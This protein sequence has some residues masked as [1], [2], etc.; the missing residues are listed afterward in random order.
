VTL[1]THIIAGLV[2]GKITGNYPLALSTSVLIDADHL[3][4]YFKSG[5]LTKPKKLWAAVTDHHDPYGDQRGYL[6]NLAVF[7]IISAIAM[8][9][10][11]VAA[12]PFVV[13]W[14]VHIILDALDK[15]PYWPLYPYKKFHISGFIRYASFQEGLFAL[16]LTV[17]YFL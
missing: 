8:L 15:S 13:A 2:V 12:Y 9:T 1:P 14:L 10:F 4:S 5:I 17:I 6:H 16:A 3:Q 11:G 7:G